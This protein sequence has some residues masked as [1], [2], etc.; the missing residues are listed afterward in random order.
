MGTI[1]SKKKKKKILNVNSELFNFN[2]IKLFNINKVQVISIFPSGI[3]ISISDDKSIKLWDK[4]F[5]ILTDIKEAHNKSIKNIYIKDENNF[6]TSSN[7]FD[8]K[9]WRKNK[10]EII[11]NKIIK[12][13]HNDI[14]NKIIYYKN[15]EIISCSNDKTLKIWQFSNNNYQLMT[16][17]K[18]KNTI[19]SLFILNDLNILISPSIDGTKFWKIN[20]DLKNIEYIFKLK[21]ATCYNPKSIDRINKDKIIIGGLNDL[22]VISI[23]ERKIIK[24]IQTMNRFNEIKSFEDKGFILVSEWS[25]KI[26]VFNIKTIQLIRIIDYG[27]VDNVI[28]F[29]KINNDLILSYSK[30]NTVILWKSN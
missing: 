10:K 21:D 18:E 15:E 26:N 12:K 7:E 8:I 27:H 30:D 22:N 9:T 29:V 5:Q 3:L 14:I 25:P 13:A 19:T 28:G 1:N 24:N 23:L 20:E 4:T 2:I 6:A 11:C 17:I 16:I